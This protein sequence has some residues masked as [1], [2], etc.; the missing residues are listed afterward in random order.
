MSQTTG[1]RFLH[2]SVASYI[3]LFLRTLLRFAW[4]MAMARLVAPEGHGLYEIA[5]RIV[6]ICSAL[7]DLGLNFHL[8]RDRRKPYGTVFV[9]GLGQSL[10]VIL[11]L[12][13]IA[14]WTTGFD[15]QLPSVLR[16]LSL[17]I[18]LDGLAVAPRIY[19]ERELR[20]SEMVVPEVARGILMAA[21]S[22]ALGALGWGVWSL[23]GGELVATG[24]FALLVWWR[25]RGRIPWQV[26][27]S[28]LPDLLRQSRWL[29]CIWVVLQL[30][31]YVDVFIIGA[32]T[33]DPA[34]VGQ[35][36]K[37]YWIAFL[38]AQ[39]V[40]PRALLPA[41]VEVRDDPESFLLA[42]RLGVVL[43]MT[44]QVVAGYFLFF[45]AARVV[46][47]LL[48]DNWDP[49]VGLLRIL[50]FV[51]FLDVF[52]DL[53]GEVLK[54]V[55]QDRAWLITGLVNLLCLVVFGALLTARWGPQGMA[56][57]NLLLLGNWLMA[58]RLASVLGRGFWR[59]GKD[60]MVI[61]LVPL[62]LFL[63]TAWL[64][65]AGS[66]WLFVVHG[67]VAALALGLL[68]RHFWP[69]LQSFVKPATEAVDPSSA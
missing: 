50:C 20:I 53:G 39:A 8:M 63:V 43:M 45:N 4:G 23:V 56:Y 16:V 30:V 49:A 5:L 42:F 48:G 29:F 55:H 31:E 22:I 52:K 58:R 32:V 38:V 60:L 47:I 35:Y 18:L 54:V 68:A 65:P 27:L 51:P 10:L 21:V 25:A 14:P 9:F 59:L 67:V 46:E 37:A 41:L 26:D 24:G 64:L 44:F 11:A 2:S 28:L 1:S 40:A 6:V 34:Q 61:Y 69:T 57:A 17:W 62:P 3:S 12:F 66:W 19:F 7:R 13:A 15:P 36:A 33:V